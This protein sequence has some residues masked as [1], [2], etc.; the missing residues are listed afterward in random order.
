M[1][2]SNETTYLQMGMAALLPGMQYMIERMQ[3]ELDSMRSQL[4]V[5]Q[6]GH[7]G[8]VRDAIVEGKRASGWSADPEE[9]KRDMARR[10]AKG[11]GLKNPKGLGHPRDPKHPGHDAWVAKLR[12]SQKKAWEAQT[13]AEKK[14]RIDKM[15]GR[16]G[17][18]RKAA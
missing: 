5:L 1:K 18:A 13:E 3:R 15:L 8:S 2:H 12:K 10:R 14:A 4:A 6:A 11:L 7:H 16:Q 9:R 17:K